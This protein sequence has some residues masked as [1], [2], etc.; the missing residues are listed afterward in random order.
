MLLCVGLRVATWQLCHAFHCLH[1]TERLACP[2][3][4]VDKD[5]EREA[6]W[7][8][9]VL[10]HAGGRCKCVIHETCPGLQMPKWSGLLCI[11]R[12]ACRTACHLRVH[13]DVEVGLVGLDCS[14]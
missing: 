7:R 11:V 12:S 8:D 3:A 13:E 1:R 6:G 9:V 5:V 10:L 4:G 2:A 14:S